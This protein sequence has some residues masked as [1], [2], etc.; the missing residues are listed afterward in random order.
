MSC[1]I[2]PTSTS[3]SASTSVA[4]GGMDSDNSSMTSSMKL[5]LHFTPGDALWFKAWTPSSGAVFGACFGLFLLSIGERLL[6]R[7]GAI[8]N[9]EWAKRSQKK[10]ELDGGQESLPSTSPEP[11][12]RSPRHLASSLISTASI[13]V[14]TN[15]GLLFTLQS[16]ISYFLML[17]VMTFNAS[18]ILSILIGLGVGEMLFGR[19]TTGL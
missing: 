2:T 4:T 17:A 13:R 19:F 1:T 6:H 5:Y 10:R 3:M 7:I 12:R 15:W 11:R 14:R 16:A 8:M 18:F 9:T